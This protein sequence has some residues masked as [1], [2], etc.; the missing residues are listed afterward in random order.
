MIKIWAVSLQLSGA[1]LLLLW[2]IKGATYESIKD[3]Y[4]P[5]SN[6]ASRDENNKCTLE[7][8]RLRQIAKEAHL[9]IIAFIDL[10]IG[11]ILSFFETSVINAGKAAFT[12]VLITIGILIVEQI[13][14]YIVALLRFRKDVLEDYSNLNGVDT[15]ATEKEIIELANRKYHDN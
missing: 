10:V 14:A 2:S 4:F 11:Y 6:I 12:M 7:K 8:K 15:E 3:K 13:L 1:L 9:N 5:G